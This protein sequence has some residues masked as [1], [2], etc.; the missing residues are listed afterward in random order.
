MSRLLIVDDDVEICALLKKFF[1]MHGY[2]VDLAANGTAMWAA[3]E[4]QRP[5]TIILD[6]MLPG[7]SGLT[8]CQKLRSSTGIPI[9]MLTAMDEL[10]DRIIGLELGADDYLGKPFDARELLAR[11]RAVQRRAG[12]QLRAQVEETRPL[13]RFDDWHLDVTRRELRT[14]QG[15]MVPLS[16]GEFDLL[17]VFLEHPQRILTREQLIDLARGHGHEA[18][19]RSIDVQVSRLRRK[20]EPDSKR[21]ALIRTVRNGGYMFDAKVS[22]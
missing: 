8:L 11:L 10:S 14:P 9:I 22:R 7:E 4:Q 12:E 19:D 18:Y 3:I 13:I 20:I 21:P 15:V 6:L 16:A 2:E 1:V 17:L 5:D